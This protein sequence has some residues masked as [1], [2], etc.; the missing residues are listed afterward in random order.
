MA[1]SNNN[2]TNF[3]ELIPSNLKKVLE[4]EYRT[5]ADRRK[6]NGRGQKLG[7]DGTPEKLFGV[8]LSGGGIRSASFCLGALQALDQYTL[9]DRMDYLSTVSGGGY[10]GSSMVAAM[11]GRGE[12]FP[13]KSSNDPGQDVRDSEAI[14]HIRDHSRFLAPRGFPDILISASIA[15]RGLMVNLILLMMVLMTLATLLIAF[16]PTLVDLQKSFAWDTL[17]FWLPGSIQPGSWKDWLKPYLI[18]PFLLSKGTALLFAL[19]LVGWALRRSYVEMYD[20][21]AIRRLFEPGSGWTRLGRTLL[22]LLVVALVIELQPKVVAYAVLLLQANGETRSSVVVAWSTIASIVAAT[23]AFRATLLGWI[24]KA[25]GSEKFGAQVRAAIAKLAFYAAGLALPLLIY[26]LFL[27]IVVWGI[28]GS[29]DATSSAVY[30]YL[31]TSG[32]LSAA[33]L[34]ALVVFGLGRSLI[35]QLFHLDQSRRPSAIIATL[36]SLWSTSTGRFILR[37]F[38]VWTAV[39]VLAACATRAD[40]YWPTLERQLFNPTS[41]GE[42]LV[43]IHYGLMSALLII[44]GLSFTENANGLHRLYRDRLK[45]AFGLHGT[46]SKTQ[47]LLLHELTTD[48]PYL[49]I[50]GTLNVRRS[51]DQAEN[52]EQRNEMARADP[53]KRGRNAEFFLFSRHFVGSD[54]TGYVE[55]ERI[56]ETEPQLDLATA[57]AISGAAVSSSMGRFNLGLLGPTLALLNLRLGFWLTNPRHALVQASNFGASSGTAPKDTRR[58]DEIL[59]LYLFNEAFGRLRADSPKIYITDGGHID[60][61]GLYQLLKRR[62][63]FIIIIDSEADAGMNFAAFCDAQRFAR[64]DE[65]VRISLDWRPIR[66]AALKRLADR[67]KAESKE[68]DVH[69]RHFAVGD[70]LYENG[71]TG[72]LIYVKASVTG[73]ESDYILDYERRNPLFPHEST[74]DQF[75]SEEQMEAYR[76]LGFHV[77]RS[78]LDTKKTVPTKPERSDP[79]KKVVPA[80][81]VADEARS[82]VE[83]FKTALGVADRNIDPV[84]SRAASK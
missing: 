14:K 32:R 84:N 8:C 33:L 74:G 78:A 39:L 30:S 5:V 6:A 16:N 9:I 22:L 57:V 66:D 24:Q 54:T 59:R 18:D 51:D 40:V 11:G 42:W 41:K 62:C 79:R 44:V 12:K 76:A 67:T 50:N 43:L 1:I 15:L 56:A 73:D 58:W 31:S 82:L 3:E 47:S 37:L 70:I 69:R 20:R 45:A 17:A 48:A 46:G 49:L 53:A 27:L 7:S 83:D 38:I 81:T 28:N 25:L 4:K 29:S 19:T 72:I 36:R 68:S 21:Q 52:D 26:G 55:S 65:G 23:A 34:A 35:V 77:M 2:S 71:E 10:A 63:K 61:L 75:F 64:I 13:F 60:N 80:A